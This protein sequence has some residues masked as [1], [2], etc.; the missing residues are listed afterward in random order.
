MSRKKKLVLA[1]I[2]GSLV[3]TAGAVG[4]VNSSKA[5]AS[6]VDM[7]P[8][9]QER[10]EELY[11]D[12]TDPSNGYFNNQGIPYHSVETMMV[13]APDQGHESTSEAASYYLWLEAMN[14]K[15]TGNFDG[16]DK[17]WDIIEKYFIPTDKDQPG[18]SSG[19]NVN[20]PATLANE[21]P[22]PDYYPA[23]LEFNSKVGVDPLYNELKNTYGKG[24]MYGMHWLIDVDNFYGY[25]SRGDGTS[26]PSYINTYQRG[27]Q[28][29]V[30]ETVPHPSWESFKWG[31]QNGYLDLFTG[32]NSYSKQW[33][34]TIASDADARCVQATY[35]AANYA[36]E[37]GVKLNDATKKASKMGD[38]LRYS[39]FDKYFMEIG[40]ESP[41]AA[42][43]KKGSQH[44]LL[45][46]YYSWG[47]ALDGSWCWRIGCSHSHFGYQNPYAAWILSN[48][49][50]F[51][52]KSSTAKEDWS[53]SLDRQLELYTWLQS[54]E[55]AIAGGCTNNYNGDYSKYPSGMS[56][57]YGMAY[58]EAPVYSDPDSNQWSG[59]QGWS[60]QRIA[61]L[62]YQTGNKMAKELMDRW[63]KW[64]VSEIKLNDDGTF[65]VPATLEWSGQPD[66]WTGRR[67]ANT[68]LHCTVKDWGTDLGVTASFANTLS[69]Y[70]AAAKKY[71]SS[72]DYAKYANVAGELLDRMW[73]LYRDDKGVAC[74]EVK[75]DFKR[76]FEQEVYVPDN[77]RGKMPNGD[78]IKSGVKFIDIRSKYKEDPDYNRVKEA[79]EKGEDITFT[80]HRFWA[81]SEIAIANAT[82][83]MLF[84]EGV[85]ETEPTTKPT[86]KPTEKPTVKPTEKPTVKPTEKPTVKPTSTPS[87]VKAEVKV[88]NDWGSGAVCSITFTNNTGKDLNNWTFECDFTRKIE[89]VFNA[90]LDSQSGD[91]IVISAP[92]WASSLKNGES[93]TIN[94]MAGASSNG[95]TTISNCSLK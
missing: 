26:T 56:T 33:R 44:Y 52:P 38:Y 47:G 61:E 49:D 85:N 77:Y 5:S 16:V 60:M 25:G 34:Y 9:Y 89:S 30:W 51:V 78:E 48:E 2:T 76:M 3:V 54:A 17:A 84:P 29:S 19:Y 93:F 42:R 43:D 65:A 4:A 53:N 11:A 13:E 50:E 40:A 28:E 79:Y 37:Y 91:H 36:K 62:Y 27:T 72:V 22:L 86:T 18:Q 12:I 81:Q 41:Q 21:Y 1:L 90:N 20:S 67:S 92:S 69:Y 45:S 24:Q 58:Q 68:G 46:W 10:F 73:D 23:K 71:D 70:A 39:M 57:F 31:G 15:V 8:K 75:N 59:M 6:S 63:S 83:G 80:Y 7:N 55:G 32:D 95:K 74:V 64:A 87:E 35:D 82:F 66:T 14:G 88:D 94:F